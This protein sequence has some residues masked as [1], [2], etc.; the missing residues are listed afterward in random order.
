MS[1]DFKT[2]ELD[3]L[4]PVQEGSTHLLLGCRRGDYSASRIARAVEDI[5]AHLLNLNVMT[6]PDDS[7]DLLIDIRINR[8]DGES[9][10]RSLERYGF[11]VISFTPGE[12]TDDSTLR[13]R[14]EEL[15]RYINV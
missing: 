14:V 8:R 12:G 10:A 2:Y 1:K 13:D 6:D 5:D 3:D 11:D 7:H 15:L 4:Y 9:A